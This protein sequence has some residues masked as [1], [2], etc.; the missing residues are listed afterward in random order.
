MA[1]LGRDLVAL[2]ARHVRLM[3]EKAPGPK[4]LLLDAETTSIISCA[5]TQSEILQKE[6]FLV[7]RLDALPSGAYEHLSA[8][9][10]LRPTNENILLL[11]RLL[12]QQGPGTDSPLLGPVDSG[13][14]PR[15]FRELH[16]FFSG[17]LQRQSE[18]LKRLARQDETDVIAQVFELF[19]D[20]YPLGPRLFSL[21][22]PALSQLQRC[23][24]RKAGESAQA[25]GFCRDA[26]RRPRPSLN[27]GLV[28]IM[29]LLLSSPLARGGNTS[30]CC[31]SLPA[32]LLTEQG[33][34]A[35]SANADAA[36][37]WHCFELPLPLLFAAD[38]E[39]VVVDSRMVDGLFSCIALLG[40]GP[41]IRFQRGSNVCQRLAAATQHR[42][43]EFRASQQQTQTQDSAAS[44]APTGRFVLLLFDR[45]EDPVT[46][47]LNQWTYTVNALTLSTGSLIISL[48][49]LSIS[50]LAKGVSSCFRPVMTTGVCGLQ[51][52]V[53][54]LLSIRHN[55][56][57]LHKVPGISEDLKEVVLSTTQDEFYKANCFSNFGDLGVA[58]K[59]HVNEYQE[60]TKTHAQIASLEAMRNFIEQ[61]PECKKMSGS[62]FKHV[63]IIHELSRLVQERQLLSVSEVEQDLATREARTEHVKSVMQFLRNPDITNMDKLRLVLLYAIRYEG[64][65]SVEPLKG[66]LR[67][68]GVDAEEVLLV[69]AI[70]QYSSAANRSGDLLQNKSL[71]AVAKNSITKGLQGVTNVYTQHKSRLKESTYPVLTAHQYG[72]PT[73]SGTSKEKLQTVVVFVVGGAT[74]EE[75]RDMD[76]LARATGVSIILGGSTMLN[77]RSFL[78][79]VSQLIRGHSLS[80][81][82]PIPTGWKQ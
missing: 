16:I 73:S 3:L 42:I 80:T 75:E 18:M 12:Q 81:S 41:L 65:P 49:H 28:W 37:Q 50:L 62:V 10:F 11:L 82:V 22:I 47:L 13:P 26:T 54:E 36:D 25:C 60:K 38:A 2:A 63:T 33:A 32:L 68:A 6:V 23:L 40:G 27:A 72:G 56:V 70:T 79:D 45:R 46:P 67:R 30:N 43:D 7:E 53:H 4:V 59:Q 58:V 29:L 15:R 76:E 19:V 20:I 61:Y 17:A 77:S 48:L 1:A 35:H 64:D 74:Y 71:L 44:A 24:C 31:W 39:L 21:N 51:A 55:R 69:D 5:V 66:E 14:P 8:V 34:G 57:D 9:C 78:A 52:M